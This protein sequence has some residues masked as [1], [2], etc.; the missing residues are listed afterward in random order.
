[1]HFGKSENAATKLKNHIDQIGLWLRIAEDGV[2]RGED[3]DA[4]REALFAG[5]K[6]MGKI[7]S[8]LKSHPILRTTV[9]ENSCDGFI[10]FALKEVG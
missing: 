10:E 5:D 8:Y 1:M 2:R 4:I 3:A 9:F 7:V 6:T